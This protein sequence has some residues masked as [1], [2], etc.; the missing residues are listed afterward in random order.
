MKAIEG[1]VM[2]ASLES[3]DD[4]KNKIFGSKKLGD[5]PKFSEIKQF[6]RHVYR[7][8][9][10]LDWNMFNSKATRLVDLPNSPFV[11]S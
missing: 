7:D 3:P 5:A 9:P 1:E 4:M 10:L 2:K 11:W 8:Y 6:F